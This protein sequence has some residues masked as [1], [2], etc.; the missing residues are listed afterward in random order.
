MYIG[1]N[2]QNGRYAH[3]AMEDRCA[4]RHAVRIGAALRPSGD[5]RFSVLVRDLSIA[6]FSAEAVTRVPPGNL[7]WLYLPGLEGIQSE[8][9]WNTGHMVGCAFSNLLSPFV[10]DRI[11]SEFRTV[12]QFV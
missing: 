8:M 6:G 12:D 5:Q 11:L 1:K 4:E 7:C 9:V 2:A 3:A 10:L